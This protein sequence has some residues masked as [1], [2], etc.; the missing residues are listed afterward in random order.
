MQMSISLRKLKSDLESI[1]SK[2]A[3][4]PYFRLTDETI[5]K[6]L[7]DRHS[8]RFRMDLL[9]LINECQPVS[10]QSVVPLMNHINKYTEKKKHNQAT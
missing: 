2:E 10:K 9:R 7:L 8:S 6:M 4:L 5:K 1:G 3:N